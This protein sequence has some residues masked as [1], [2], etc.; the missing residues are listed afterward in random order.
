[1]TVASSLPLFQ[2][3]EPPARIHFVGIGG[4]GMSGL[5]RIFLARG[6]VVS[7]SDVQASPQTESL[8]ALGVPITIGH[9]D[10][11][12]AKLADLVVATAAVPSGNPEL[13]AAHAAIPAD[14]IDALAIVG[15]IDHACQRLTLLKRAGIT[16]IVVNRRD[17]PPIGDWSNIIQVLKSC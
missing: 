15:S 13:E 16:E 9:T 3:P 11:A 4:I 5:A 8:E 6:Y 17:L 14:L 12:R 2:L 10:V 1:M 7:G